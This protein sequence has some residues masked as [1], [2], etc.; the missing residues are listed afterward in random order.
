MFGPAPVLTSSQLYEMA[1]T[2]ST[3]SCCLQE[4]KWWQAL[5]A[6]LAG[7]PLYSLSLCPGLVAAL[8]EAGQYALIPLVAAQVRLSV[9]FIS[10]CAGQPLASVQVC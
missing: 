5:S 6:L 9:R 1:I 4:R 10:G 3:P 2:C 7:Q 8:A